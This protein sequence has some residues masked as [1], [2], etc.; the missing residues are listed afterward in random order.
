M[1]WQFCNNANQTAIGAG[2]INIVKAQQWTS[3]ASTQNSVMNFSIAKNG[4]VANVGMFSS[5]GFVIGTGALGS[6]PTDSFLWLPS[7]SGT[8]GTPAATPYT[9]AAAVV[10][11]SVNS[12]LFVRVGTTWKS[13]NLT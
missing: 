3:T 2:G 13:V 5:A 7:C 9:D 10:V 4:S 12:K 6:A 11:D 8:P 1:I